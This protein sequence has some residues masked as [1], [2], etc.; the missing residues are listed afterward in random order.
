MAATSVDSYSF[1][2]DA[3]L[4]AISATAVTSAHAAPAVPPPSAA[5]SETFGYFV[6][7]S[8]YENSSTAATSE[9]FGYFV[10][11][12][13]YENSSTAATSETFGYFV[14]VSHYENSSIAAISSLRDASLFDQ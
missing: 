14:P 5:S 12:S 9:T 7:V 8:R 4:D 3:M 10:P 1:A 11:V 13:H 2:K 6:P